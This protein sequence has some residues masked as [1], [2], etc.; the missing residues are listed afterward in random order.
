MLRLTSTFNRTLAL[1]SI[2]PCN[3]SSHIDIHSI[4]ELASSF[5]EEGKH[6]LY[7]YKEGP[8]SLYSSLSFPQTIF[9]PLIKLQKLPTMFDIL[10]P[11]SYDRL[12][13]LAKT[14]FMVRSYQQDIVLYIYLLYE[15]D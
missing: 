7:T 9:H 2:F 13:D 8:P 15:T 10:D 12:S 1:R 3:D 5:I 6:Y 4:G 11:F 14:P